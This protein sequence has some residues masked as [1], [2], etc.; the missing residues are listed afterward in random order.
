MPQACTASTAGSETAG[1]ARL[2][3]S[4]DLSEAFTTICGLPREAER[5]GSAAGD[6]CREAN[7]GEA[8]K[9]SAPGIE[10]ASPAAAPSTRIRIFQADFLP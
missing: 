8:L 4:S 10:T 1:R 9:A 6:R 3:S 7:P 2:C 5:S